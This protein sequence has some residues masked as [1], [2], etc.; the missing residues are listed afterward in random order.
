MTAFLAL[1]PERRFAIKV[2]GLRDGDSWLIDSWGNPK[3]PPPFDDFLESK[4][5]YA[6]FLEAIST[7]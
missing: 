7:A 4:P 5:A 3:W 1:P 2:W 6:G